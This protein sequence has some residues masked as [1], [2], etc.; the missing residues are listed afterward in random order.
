[1]NFS[2]FDNLKNYF[3]T[4]K[5]SIYNHLIN[6]TFDTKG[7]RVYALNRI[8]ENVKNTRKASGGAHFRVTRF[9]PNKEVGAYEMYI[10]WTKS[11]QKLGEDFALEIRCDVLSTLDPHTKVVFDFDN[12]YSKPMTKQ[13]IKRKGYISK[14]VYLIPVNKVT[15]YSKQETQMK[16]DFNYDTFKPEF[17]PYYAFKHDNHKTA[18]TVK[19]II[20]GAAI[21]K[22]YESRKEFYEDMAKKGM[23]A[24]TLEKFLREHSNFTFENMTCIFDESW[25]VKA[26]KIR[27]VV[28][29]IEKVEDIVEDKVVATETKE[30]ETD[31]LSFEDYKNI[32]NLKPVEKEEQIFEYH[33]L[34]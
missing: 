16:G 29:V 17:I 3:Q 32:Y 19:F 13:E 27:K 8:N 33:E 2:Q 11:Y 31:L 20:N 25:E 6:Y 34:D 9:L 22:S 4:N 28:K 12:H 7:C 5:I 30:F 15:F 10:Y 24:C 21:N 26:Y 1:M 23:K 18:F 14:G